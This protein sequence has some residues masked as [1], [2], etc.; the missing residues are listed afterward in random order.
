MA[1]SDLWV[2]TLRGQLLNQ[3]IVN[4]FTYHCDEPFNATTDGASDLIDG[5]IINVMLGA[6]SN[7]LAGGNK[8][9]SLVYSEIEAYN[10]D[11]PT[12]FEIRLVNYV[13]S[14]ADEQSPS[15]LAVGYSS[16]KP[17]RD[18][19]RGQKRIAGLTENQCANNALIAAVQTEWQNVGNDMASVLPV[20]PLTGATFTP[21]VIKRVKYVASSGNDAYR[22][23]EPGEPDTHYLVTEWQLKTAITSQVS[24]KVGHGG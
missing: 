11:E 15:F 3:D 12:A 22:F 5:F 7:G 21:C 23:P 17:R 19:R 20:G 6:T 8:A 13:G 14:S 4:V 18:I 9:A 2:L 24:R 1:L 16:N 10:L